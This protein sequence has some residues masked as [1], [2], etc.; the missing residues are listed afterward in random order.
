MK[1]KKMTAFILSL[2]AVLGSFSG[3][4][5]VPP[6]EEGV[7][8]VDTANTTSNAPEGDVSETSDTSDIT[9]TSSSDTKIAEEI[10]TAAAETTN[11]TT[12]A[13]TEVPTEKSEES[14]QT[15][16]EISTAEITTEKKEESTTAAETEKTPAAEET[17]AKETESTV[18]TLAVTEKNEETGMSEKFTIGSAELV[19]AGQTGKKMSGEFVDSQ[20]QFSVAMFK[21]SV[22][23]G[24]GG[25]LLVSPLS[26]IPALTMAA[27]GAK[28]ETL[29]EFE[30]VIGG[31][32]GIDKFNEYLSAYLNSLSSGK[33]FRLHL[34]DSIWIKDDEKLK[35]EESFLQD[36]KSF[37]N[38]EIY[39]ESFDNATVEKI[40]GWVGK[41]TDGMIDKIIDRLDPDTIMCLI[42]AL[43]FDAKWSAPYDSEY[44]VFDEN[45]TLSN[46]TVKTAEMMY[47]EENVYLKSEN[48]VGFMKPYKGGKYSFAALL[49]NTGVSTKEFVNSLTGEK[50]KNILSGS[51]RCAVETKMPKFSFDYDLKLD[52]ILKDMGLNKAFDVDN[53]DFTGIGKIEGDNIYVGSVLQKTFIAVD[54]DGTKAGASTAVVMAAGAT[55]IQPEKK[56]VYLDR[57]FVFMIVDN[58]NNLPIFMGCVENAGK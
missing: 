5:Q 55:A 41:N 16:T 28:G 56:R 34:A 7:N 42:N 6:E 15:N 19:S 11:L 8:I 12:T 26:A 4:N 53:A 31:G 44:D 38:A 48:A 13:Q 22:A 52:D 20:L 35:I 25:N 46:G 21:D 24:D 40:N 50:L 1:M 51:E 54:E 2:A 57:P 36:N 33:D 14:E 23:K 29:S 9:D 32:I 10:T 49:P 43:A 45:F 47:S 58:E 27:N 18:S 3:C 39:R 30:K 17:T 37:Y